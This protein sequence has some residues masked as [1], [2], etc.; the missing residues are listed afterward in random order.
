MLNQ[1]LKSRRSFLLSE[2]SKAL[3]MGARAGGGGHFHRPDRKPM[4]PYE[5]TA[6]HHLEDVNTVFYHDFAPEYHLHL[7]SPFVQNAKQG[8]ALIVLYYFLVILP[9]W[10]FLTYLNKIS[11]SVLTPSVRPGKDH[12]HMA[13]RLIEYLK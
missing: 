2:A 10:L 12:A 6:L 13:P 1:L 9:A 5:Y 8:I 3:T 4:K 11:G 7:H